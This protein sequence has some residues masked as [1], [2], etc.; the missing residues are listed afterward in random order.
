MLETLQEAR[1]NGFNGLKLLEYWHGLMEPTGARGGRDAFFTDVVQRAN[2]VSR[3]IFFQL[4]A[5]NILADE[6]AG[7]KESYQ[8]E[9]WQASTL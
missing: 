6:V 9:R 2:S 4:S 5:L 8:R 3:F 7:A 1:R